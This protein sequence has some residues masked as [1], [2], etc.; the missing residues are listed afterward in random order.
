LALKETVLGVSDSTDIIS[1]I[2]KRGLLAN[3]ITAVALLL[4][5][6]HIYTT[7]AG[8]PNEQL[9]RGIHVYTVLLLIF[10]VTYNKKNA[11][12]YRAISLFG[13]FASLGLQFFIWNQYQ[14]IP[15]RLG[16]ATQ[17][18][19]ILGAISVFLVLEATRRI[20][21]PPMAILALVFLAYT[22]Y[23]KYFPGEIQHRGYSW[24]SIFDLQFLSLNGIFTV[25]VATAATYI[26]IFLIFA[27]FLEKS[28]ALEAFMN[29]A[30][31]LAG[32]TIGGP[33]KVAVIASGLMGMASGAAAAN[34]VVTGNI[35]IPLMKRLGYDKNFA[36]AVE[37]CASSGGQFMPPIMG[38]AAFIIAAT[39]SIPYLDVCKHAAIPATFWFVACYLVVHFEAQRLNLKPLTDEYIPSTETVLRGLYLFIPI[40]VLVITLALGYTPMRAGGMALLCLFVLTFVRKETRFNLVGLVDALE[41][42][43]RGALSVSIACACAGVIIGCVMQTGLGFYLSA[44]L[45]KMS[46]GSLWVLMILVVIASLVLGMGMVTVGAYIIVSTLVSPAMVQMGVPMIAA[47]LFP[48]YFAIISAITPP[49]AIASYT[50]AGLAG[51]NPWNTGVMGMRL[52][53]PALIIPFIFVF[54]PGLLLIGSLQSIIMTVFSTLFAVIALSAFVIGY[55]GKELNIVKRIILLIA[56]ILLIFPQVLPTVVGFAIVAAMYLMHRVSPSSAVR[57]DVAK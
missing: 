33:A 12:W 38:A 45:V 32:K 4:G 26:I 25:P 1:S 34:V 20:I 35:S 49:V 53:I 11:W 22:R 9:H 57:S 18:D 16:A 10:L 44:A 31:K 30:L 19:L 14:V 8:C 52:A 29:L 56:A 51:A 27:G 46:G 28:G 50:A 6:Y 37:A 43:I 42:S 41:Y 36:G 24:A 13:I 5:I 47:H 2:K 3:T 23:G 48:F 15:E 39:L 17:L 55:F 21:G 54:Q 40:F 7:F